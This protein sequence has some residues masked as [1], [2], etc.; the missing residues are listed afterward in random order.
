MHP[1]VNLV[2]PLYNE[3]SVFAQLID[4]L[5][6]VMD[7]CGLRVEVILIDDGSRDETPNLM[8]QLSLSDPRFQSIFLS[9]NF[10][11]QLALTSGLSFVNATDAVMVIDGDLQDPPELLTEFYEY[12]QKGYDVVYAVR[13]KRKEGFLQKAAYKSF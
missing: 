7:I 1:Q 6:G 2:V 8:R 10:G 12:Y 9:R 11:H 5:R 13:K 3:E 4:R